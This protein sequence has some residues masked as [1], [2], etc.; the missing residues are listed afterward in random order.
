MAERAKAGSPAGCAQQHA[1][2][3]AAGREPLDQAVRPAHPAQRILA[4]H[5]PLGA[6]R[7]RASGLFVG[8]FFLIPGVQIIGAALFCVP[9]RGNIP[10]A[11]GMTF[12]TNPFTTP[13]PDPRL[14]PGRQS[15]RLP[16]RQRRGHGR[17]T[18]AAPRSA[19]GWPGSPRTRRRRWSRP[20]H[21][22]AG[23]S[24]AIGY[25]IVELRLALVDRRASGAAARRAGRARRLIGAA[26]SC[27]TAATHPSHR[28]SS[29]M[30]KLLS[31]PPPPR[32][33]PSSPSPPTPAV[34]AAPPAAAARP[35][36]RS[37]LR[38]RPRR[39]GPQRR[40]RRQFLP[41]RQRQ[42]GPD[43]RN[44]RRPRQ[45]RHVHRAR[46]SVRRR[47][48]ASILE[49][50]TRTPGLADRRFLCELHGRG[51]GRAP[52]ASRRCARC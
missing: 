14:D 22:R 5:P 41:L 4:L 10:I 38:L 36:R 2:P 11:A 39:H 35:A 34:P 24:G 47:A 13:V 49:E 3:R 8:V 19:N 29:P 18:R 40:A 51:R 27:Y 43:H 52:P 37:A 21:H 50:A 12:L 44:P 15:V 17:C 31:S 1:E 30:R 42:L 9:V 26:A 32:S 23:V 16:R 48:P 45:L 33:P 6:A 20:V 28:G 25:F 46:R 7:R